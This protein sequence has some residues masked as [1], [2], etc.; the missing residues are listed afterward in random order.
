[1][2]AT[3]TPNTAPASNADAASAPTTAPTPPEMTAAPTSA[4]GSPSSGCHP[5]ATYAG[6]FYKTLNMH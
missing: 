2:A 6:E 1:M 5:T 4:Q 3:S